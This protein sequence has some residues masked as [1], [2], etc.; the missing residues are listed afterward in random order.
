[1][2]QN[3]YRKAIEIKDVLSTV[4]NSFCTVKWKHATLN[5]GS[6][7][8]KSCCHLPFRKIESENLKNG[9]ELHDTKEDRKERATMLKGGRP[10]NCS[11]CWWLEDKNQLSNRLTWSS[12]SWMPKDVVDLIEKRGVA[13]HSPA[14]LEINFSNICNLKCSYCSPIFST[15]WLQEIKEYGAYP[16]FP[17]HNHLSFLP[18]VEFN[19]KYDNTKLMEQF[20][21]W[22]DGIYDE[23]R[24]L[25]LTGGEPLLSHQTTQLLKKICE[26]P[27]KNLVLSVNSN[28]SVPEVNWQ[29]FIE[30]VQKLSQH[31]I[32][33]FFLHPSIDT[34]GARAEYIRYGLDFSLFQKHVR[35]F[36][37]VTSGSL[38][39]ICTLNNLSLGGLLDFW[40]YL[41]EL[42]Q[43]YGPRGKWVSVNTEV[44][45]SPEWQNI[46]I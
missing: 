25:K 41:F 35:D 44:L 43:E 6:G 26:K 30:L 3:E 15:K 29:T 20:W 46:K 4:S 7:A 11:Y 16:T 28:L 32:S 9:Y 22:F 8:V 31:K 2:D 18:G 27:N 36:L 39:F 13:A 17:R 10:T 40:R 42:K 38:V 34:Y 19:E 12:K 24:L 37:E 33:K 1:M 5:L 14:W 23:L 21:P 45:M